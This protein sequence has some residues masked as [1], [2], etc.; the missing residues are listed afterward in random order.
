MAISQQPNA[1][2]LMPRQ[3]KGIRKA[4]PHPYQLYA[5]GK[6][7]D[8]KKEF[9]RDFDAGD[10]LFKKNPQVLRLTFT[11]QATI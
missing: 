7:R 11:H 4:R 8:D 2:P 6:L 10:E 1:S 9:I 5:N 3:E